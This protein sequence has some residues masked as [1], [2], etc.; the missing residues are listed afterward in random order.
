MFIAFTSTLQEDGDNNREDGVSMR[1]LQAKV[2]VEGSPK[3]RKSDAD[4]E[5]GN[6]TKQT[7]SPQDPNGIDE[8]GS[9]RKL[10]RINQPEVQQPLESR[11]SVPMSK[12]ATSTRV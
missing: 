11:V 8:S 6:N 7:A 5:N 2:D 9:H 1:N 3:R 12:N 10:T 4:I